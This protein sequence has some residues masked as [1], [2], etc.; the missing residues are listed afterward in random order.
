MAQGSE[1]E[2]EIVEA[3]YKRWVYPQP[4]TDMQETIANHG[5]YD[6]SDPSL[7]RRKL[8]PRKIEPDNLNIL[9]AGCGTNQAAYYAMTNP[10]A[11]V[12]GIDVSESSLRHGAYLKEKHG[13]D[14]LELHRLSL[15]SIATLGQYFD[16]IV[17]TGVLHHLPDPDVGLRCLR[18]VLRPH[19][20]ISV[21]VYGYYPRFGVYMMQKAFHVLGLKQDAEGIGIVRCAIR[22][23]PAWHHLHAYRKLVSDLGDDS[24]IVDTFLHPVDRA[25]TVSQVLRLISSTN[26][27]LQS[28]LDNIDYSVSACIEDHTSPVRQ[29]IERLELPEQ[30]R[31]IEI[32]AQSLAAH[33]FLVCRLEKDDSEYGLNFEG[34]KWVDY[35]PSLRPPVEILNG[36]ETARMDIG[37]RQIPLRILPQDPGALPG[38]SESESGSKP[39]EW[40][41]PAVIRRGWHASELTR[42]EAALLGEIDGKRPIRE[43]LRTMS[44]S[45]GGPASLSAARKLFLRMADW[46]HL[47]FRIP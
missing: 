46:D 3:Q 40:G 30:W 14:N 44:A 32:I 47:Q 29:I 6:L 19:G 38:R 28:W 22:E 27:K 33:R 4:I 18:D 11:Q 7:F 10:E 37:S 8:W 34:E 20:V 36:T 23:I 1:I 16:L 2:S 21:M 25:F 15:S 24:E 35:V 26:M 13:L 43:L 45:S 9:I 39:E 12:T 31:L 17:C 41:P 42:F 5:Y